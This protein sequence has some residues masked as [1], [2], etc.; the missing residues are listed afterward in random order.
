MIKAITVGS[1]DLLHEGHKHL[2][3]ECS[4]NSDELII[5]V[6]S[7]DMYKDNKKLIPKF[8]EEERKEKVCYVLKDLNIKN[9]SVEI[10]D[11]DVKEFISWIKKKGC[12]TFFL[13]YDQEFLRDEMP[14]KLKDFKFIEISAFKPEKYKSSKLKN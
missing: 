6:I 3:K 12:N 14:N 5:C 7:D 11:H 10:I 1:F 13:G 4:K 9:S 8:N 2:I